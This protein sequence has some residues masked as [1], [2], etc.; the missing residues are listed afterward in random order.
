M[1]LETPLS[2][3]LGLKYPFVSAPMFLISNKEMIVAAAEAGILGCMPSLNSRT[4]E[5]LRDDLA[6][7]RQRTDRG[8]GINITLGLTPKERIEADM[9]LCLEFGVQVILSSYGNPTAVTK[10]AH[11]HGRLVFHDVIGL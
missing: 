9:A 5:K 6:W 4:A 8:F 1:K 7:I 3:K 2:K 11:D 10:V